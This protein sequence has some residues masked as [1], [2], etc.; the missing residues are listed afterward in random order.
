M[1]YYVL[2]TLAEINY[3]Y[4]C[5][6]SLGEIF[7][8][9]GNGLCSGGIDNLEV[10]FLDFGLTS[11]HPSSLSAVDPSFSDNGEK[12]SQVSLETNTSGTRL[13]AEC[14]KMSYVPDEYPADGKVCV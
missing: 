9:I 6:C 1:Y 5:V 8:H 3:T 12:I 11:C 7:T 2:C 13:S 14:L 4:I 10:G